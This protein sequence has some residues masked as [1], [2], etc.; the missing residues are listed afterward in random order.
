MAKGTAKPGATVTRKVSKGPGKGDLVQFK[1]NS[2][3]AK[4]PG[5]LKP[6]RVIKDVGT[7]G[8]Q[9]SLPKG[10]IKRKGGGGTNRS[11][12]LVNKAFPKKKHP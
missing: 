8:T 3:S 4:E 2:A 12:E 1:A 10:K 9:A 5:K 11:A 6:R 7:K